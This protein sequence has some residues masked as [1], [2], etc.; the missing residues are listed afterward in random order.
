MQDRNLERMVKIAEILRRV[1]K[2]TGIAQIPIAILTKTTSRLENYLDSNIT[3]FFL[4]GA[5][6]ATSLI[7]KVEL[8]QE[9]NGEEARQHLIR[10]GIYGIV[11]NPHYFGFRLISLGWM[12]YNPS[13]E[14]LIAGTALFLT[15]ELTARAEERKLEYLYAAEYQK[16]KEKVPRW[17]PYLNHVK[18]FITKIKD[19]A[20][21]SFK[22][23]NQS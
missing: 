22:R 19:R 14:N 3:P 10:N 15:T 5:G 18:P 8:H 23:P 7:A 20:L 13:I 6:A 12:M 11:R 4:L 16:Y 21:N 9:R 2:Y 17:I 1:N